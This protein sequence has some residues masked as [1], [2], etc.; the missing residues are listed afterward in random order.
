[1]S[2]T[3]T[4]RSLKKL[5]DFAYASAVSGIGKIATWPLNMIKI[6]Q[7][8]DAQKI[9][10]LRADWKKLEGQS[11]R[12]GFKGASITLAKT[13][14][15]NGIQM[16]LYRA[17][18]FVDPNAKDAGGGVKEHSKK[19]KSIS[20]V[21]AGN[22]GTFVAYW[23][24]PWQTRW[25]RRKENLT[26]LTSFQRNQ[27][28]FSE[29]RAIFREGGIASLWKGASSKMISA[30]P[31]NFGFGALYP[32]FTT[33]FNKFLQSRVSPETMSLFTRY[34]LF[35][36]LG[37]GTAAGSVAMCTHWLDTVVRTIQATPNVSNIK[38]TSAVQK[39]GNEF[40]N[41]DRALVVLYK[42]IQQKHPTS[43]RLRILLYL[44][45]R[46]YR[47]IGLNVCK[48]SMTYAWK[49]GGYANVVNSSVA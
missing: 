12:T 39:I 49:W 3:G 45:R 32:T 34:K 42:D 36:A 38:T 47:G 8:V 43:S 23:M 4:E 30:T 14:I 13:M 22:G 21:I 27:L 10:E 33:H 2:Q 1:M 11:F 6:R 41:F 17:L 20:N 9:S 25:L 37:A 35:D 15:S 40:R 31:F 16:P 7:Q 5:Q 48:S 26:H 28:M 29:L 24:E 18:I 46:L 44:A 19:W